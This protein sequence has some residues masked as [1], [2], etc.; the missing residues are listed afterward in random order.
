M[1]FKVRILIRSLRHRLVPILIDFL[2][3]FSQNAALFLL[4]IFLYPQS[5]PNFY[6]V[7]RPV[8][9]TITILKSALI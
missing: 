7:G 6:A 8:L 4:L 1:S 5:T 2:M 9:N 3:I